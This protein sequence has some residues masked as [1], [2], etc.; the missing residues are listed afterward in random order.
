MAPSP[1]SDQ[2]DLATV[3]SALGAQPFTAE[4]QAWGCA[5]L[6]NITEEAGTYARSRAIELGALDLV[7]AALNQHSQ[8]AQ[9]QECGCAALGGLAKDARSRGRAVSLGAIDLALNA[10]KQHPAEEEVQR[11]GL[12]ALGELLRHGETAGALAVKGG[13][14]ELALVAMQLHPGASQVQGCSC[15]LLALLAL[16]KASAVGI[17]VADIDSGAR[18]LLYSAMQEHLDAEEVQACGCSAIGALAVRGS[19]SLQRALVNDGGFLE[20]VIAAIRHHPSSIAVQERGC[21]A[22][23]CLLLQHPDLTASDTPKGHAA[24]V[25]CALELGAAGVLV[26]A[27]LNHPG[28]ATVQASALTALL[29]LAM[30]AT[31]DELASCQ[32]PLPDLLPPATPQD[33]DEATLLQSLLRCPDVAVVQHAALALLWGRFVVDIAGAPEN[34]VETALLSVQALRLHPSLPRIQALAC[35]ALSYSLK[36]AWAIVV[37]S[38]DEFAK[39]IYYAVS[40]FVDDPEVQ[41]HGWRA[42]LMLFQVDGLAAF[43][44]S[45]LHELPQLLVNTMAGHP[46]ATLQ[47]LCCECI[48]CLCLAVPSDVDSQHPAHEDLSDSLLA[49]GAAGLVCAALEAHLTVLDVQEAGCTALQALVGHDGSR[50]HRQNVEMPVALEAAILNALWA[51]PESLA[52]QIRGLDLVSALAAGNSHKKGAGRLLA[53][54]DLAL[55]AMVMHQFV[56]DVFLIAAETLMRLLACDAGRDESPEPMAVIAS[57]LVSMTE[58]APDLPT[59]TVLRHMGKLCPDVATRLVAWNGVDALLEVMSGHPDSDTVQVAAA[60]LLEIL[61]ARCSPARGRLL[62]RAAAMEPVLHAMGYHLHSAGVQASCC[63]LLTRLS[64]ESGRMLPEVAELCLEL[65]L[66]A[67]RAHPGDALIDTWGFLALQNMCFCA[68][69]HAKFKELG[70]L[71]LVA[72]RMQESRRPAPANSASQTQETSRALHAVDMFQAVCVVTLYSFALDDEEC[73]GSLASGQALQLLR[74]ALNAPAALEVRERACHLLCKAA[75]GSEKVAADFLAAG[76]KLWVSVLGVLREHLAAAEAEETENGLAEPALPEIR[77]ILPSPSQQDDSCQLLGKHICSPSFIVDAMRVLS[78]EPRVQATAC[79]ALRRQALLAAQD[80][81]RD[82]AGMVQKRHIAEELVVAAL[83][84][85]ATAAEVQQRGVAAIQA[86]LRLSC[87]DACETEED[88]LQKIAA[89]KDSAKLVA[90]ERRAVMAAL[91]EKIAVAREAAALGRLLDLGLLPLLI[92]A[93]HTYPDNPTVQKHGLDVLRMMCTGSRRPDALAALPGLGAVQ[94]VIEGINANIARPKILEYGCTVLA[95]LSWMS[96]EVQSEVGTKHGVPTVV[97]TMKAFPDSCEVQLA[98]VS[99]VQAL[100][101]DHDVNRNKFF[102][103]DD[104]L[105]LV[106]EAVQNFQRSEPLQA[107]GLAAL[108]GLAHTSK[109]RTEALVSLSA[110]TLAESAKTWHLRSERVHEIANQLIDHLRNLR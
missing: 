48:S 77:L 42:L 92:K 18:S 20:M 50:L 96:A 60:G 80:L 69:L 61:A 57:T 11:W 81:G 64:T 91:Q 9:V 87:S 2:P 49:L 5:A 52:V 95:E 102:S 73:C 4:V 24:F 76:P 108:L 17:T 8:V 105:A 93:L 22:L 83:R 45:Q 72:Q 43:E 97:R 56:P 44:H 39:C 55:R 29:C 101:S 103:E 59:K 28:I 40:A 89:E 47:Q 31:E 85:H 74:P 53:G 46:R 54:V 41:E 27:L 99:A 68:D 75:L 32:V 34:C 86:L 14:L 63:A 16:F 35:A 65:V 79:M 38:R 106:V 58:L 10:L 25:T 100:S 107:F 15:A 88:A 70:A 94:T 78:S 98:A 6:R 62:T 19:V 71:Q 3:I 13:C 30:P 21:S 90:A 110:L 7:L 12:S 67:L 51:Q 66:A 33:C 23:R 36:P 104:I 82:R 1:A 37:S 84:T 109:D 26:D